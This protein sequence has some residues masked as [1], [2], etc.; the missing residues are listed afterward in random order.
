MLGL[1]DWHN[2]A[3]FSASGLP[4]WNEYIIYLASTEQNQGDQFKTTGQGSGRLLRIILKYN[5]SLNSVPNGAQFPNCTQL[6]Q[7][8]NND[9]VQYPNQVAADVQALGTFATNNT[10]YTPSQ[11]SVSYLGP[12]FAFT[13]Y[14][15]DPNTGCP[16]P[17]FEITYKERLGTSR[18][19]EGSSSTGI[20]TYQINLEIEPGT[21]QNAPA[22]ND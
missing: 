15:C 13:V 5:T 9:L 16:A 12:V 14:R 11:V 17:L 20:E 3:N 2:P 10:T 7:N 18:I 1:S 22:Y 8:V 4:N 19:E 21:V 6:V